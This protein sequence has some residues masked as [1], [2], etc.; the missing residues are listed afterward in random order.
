MASIILI[1]LSFF[2]SGSFSLY[3]F[4]N[5]LVEPALTA[6]IFLYLTV[7]SNIHFDWSTTPFLL[8]PLAIW[9]GILDTIFLIIFAGSFDNNTYPTLKDGD[10]NLIAEY[11]LIYVGIYEFIYFATAL[12]SNYEKYGT[13]GSSKYFKFSELII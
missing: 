5:F 12:I 1:V 4:F 8:I 3:T 13:Y 10:W 6:G 9:E 11:T 2:L 7:V